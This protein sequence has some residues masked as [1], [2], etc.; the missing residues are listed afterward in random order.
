MH[1]I[2]QSTNGLVE[3][4]DYSIPHCMRT[5]NREVTEIFADLSDDTVFGIVYQ[6][7]P[8]FVSTLIILG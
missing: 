1:D 3:S 7:I 2:S 5:G 6:P 8:I 4:H